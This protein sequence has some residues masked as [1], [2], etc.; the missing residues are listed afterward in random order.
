MIKMLKVIEVQPQA[1]YRLCV[2]LSNGKSGLFDVAPY[3][4]KGIFEELKDMRYFKLVSPR[5]VVW[6]GRIIRIL[7]RTRLMLK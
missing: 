7:V 6:L 3:L 2:K 1:N 4:E 5:L